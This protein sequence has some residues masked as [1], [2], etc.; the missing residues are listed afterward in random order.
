MTAESLSTL[1]GC[2]LYIAAMGRS[3]STMLANLLHQPPSHICL[4]EPKLAFG[5]PSEQSLRRLA[6]TI[7]TMGA[8]NAS[9]LVK[10]LRASS[11]WGV[12]EVRPDIHDQSIALLQP[13]HIVVLLRDPFQASLSLYE[14]AARDGLLDRPEWIFALATDAMASLPRVAED[15]R[16]ITI[17][18]ERF[19]SDAEVRTALAETLNWPLDGDAARGLEAI[20]RGREVELHKGR[21]TQKSLARDR[22]KATPDAIEFA[23]RAVAHADDVTALL[24]RVNTSSDGLGLA[25]KTPA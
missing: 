21:I 20:G 25:A 19:V 3:G 6:S 22:S 11:K 5:A 4:V 2:D 9:E 12:K 18:Y 14:K 13:K 8:P 1:P 16:A 17:S 10:H 15:P 24:E 23:E 7:P